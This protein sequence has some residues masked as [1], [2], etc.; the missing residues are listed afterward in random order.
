MK[1]FRI[2]FQITLLTLIIAVG[3][4]VSGYLVYQ[5]LS[6]I[7]DSI[8]QEARPDFKLI[9]IKEIASDLNEVENS[10]RLFS[11]TGNEEFISSYRK[12]YQQAQQNLSALKDYA[13]PGSDEIQLIDSIS[14]LSTLKLNLW[15]QIRQLHQQKN[16]QPGRPLSELVTRIDTAFIQPDTIR[17]EAPKKKGFFK[18]I[19]GKQDTVA[20][21]PVI[22]SKAKEKEQIKQEIIQAEEQINSEQATLSQSEKVLYQ[23]HIQASR[24]IDRLINQL[25]TDEQRRLERK[26]EEADGMAAQIYRRLVLFTAAS[27]ILLIIVLALFYR[28]LQHN[29]AYQNMLKKA[30]SDAENLAKAKERF[31]ATVSHELRTPVN[32]IFGLSEQLL[33]Q[34][35]DDKLKTDLNIVHQSANHLLSLVNDTLDFAKIESQ[36]M[37]FQQSGFFPTK[38][39]AEVMAM[40][41]VVADAKGLSLKLHNSIPPERVYCGDPLRLK[42]ITLNLLSNAIKFTKDGTVSLELSEEL[43][44]D[45]GFRLN[46]EVVDSG[47]GIPADQIPSI[48][49]EFIQLNNQQA[50]KQR[51][52]GLGLTIVKKLVELQGGHISV[53]SLVGQGSCFSVSIPYAEGVAPQTPEPAFAEAPEWFRKLKLLAVDDEDFNLYLLKNILDK[54]NVA[55]QLA[56]NGQEAVEACRTNQFDLIL[57]D[58]HMPVLN[59]LEASKQIS[60][61]NPR[62]KIVVLTAANRPEEQE[63]FRQA[64]IGVFLQK[65]FPEQSLFQLLLELD[66]QTKLTTSNAAPASA[67][68]FDF[69]ELRNSLGGDDKFLK[70]MI[71]LF[72]TA[73][74]NG[75]TAMHE[76]RQTRN[77]EQLSEAG[78]KLA[79]PARHMQADQLYQLLKK[80]ETKAT[81]Q[82]E[83][84]ELDELV[85]Q[86]EQEIEQFC[87]LLKQAQN[88]PGNPPG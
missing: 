9:L 63:Q 81:D 52:T 45:K 72:Q 21:A 50:E 77:R 15:G 79:A 32:A 33:Q 47:S 73:A 35:V 74:L 14:Q 36:K 86:A 62:A 76:S 22:I 23:R 60:S 80:L 68:G 85:D 55:Y 34:P 67:P 66:A 56:H 5:S 51:G 24:Q 65:P 27:I 57:M 64:G 69:N 26:T 10:V 18:R 20:K 16:L 88:D 46:L 49:E 7:I 8:H 87:T 42:Q 58:M 6:Q 61:E 39:F 54:W 75:L 17:F 4:A 40:Q 25:E 71:E 2:E 43:L 48:F 29:K 19:F 1:F 84:N 13:I 30:R 83:W 78:H 38:L 82:T 3:V 59:G 11:L 53:K 70:E 44:P 28:N 37:S 12:G 41:K 31:V